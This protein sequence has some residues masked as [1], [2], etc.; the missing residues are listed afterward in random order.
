M[1]SVELDGSAGGAVKFYNMQKSDVAWAALPNN[2]QQVAVTESSVHW[3][4]W[5]SVISTTDVTR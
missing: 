4:S 1:L 3:Y 2:N 5:S